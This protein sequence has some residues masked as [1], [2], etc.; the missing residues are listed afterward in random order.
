MDHHTLAFTNM[1]GFSGK[2]WRRL[3]F[4]KRKDKD[5]QREPPPLRKVSIDIEYNKAC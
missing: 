1:F 4:F 2:F 3:Q 5:L